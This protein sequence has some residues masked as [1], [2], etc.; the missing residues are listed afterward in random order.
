[1]L[2]LLLHG[3]FRHIANIL[4]RMIDCRHVEVG[5]PSYDDAQEALSLACGVIEQGI[6]YSRRNRAVRGREPAW[7]SLCFSYVMLNF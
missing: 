3:I 2:F 7:S 4:Q 1:M 5:T 6:I